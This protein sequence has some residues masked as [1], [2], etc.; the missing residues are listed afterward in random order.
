MLPQ[1]PSAG[2]PVTHPR[3]PSKAASAVPRRR[4]SPKNPALRMER[5][6]RA[7]VPATRSGR[8]AR[9]TR[10]GGKPVLTTAA[11]ASESVRKPLKSYELKELRWAGARGGPRRSSPTDCRG[12]TT[13]RGRP[14]PNPP[15]PGARLHPESR[16][17]PSSAAPAAAPSPGPPGIAT[18]V[19]PS[20]PGAGCP[21]RA[22]PAK[23]A[24]ARTLGPIASDVTK[25][26]AR[27]HQPEAAIASS[28]VSAG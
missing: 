22:K 3:A 17:R 26:V 15:G 10:S 9:A 2:D 18:T 19:E 14:A 13:R 4:V 23:P 5:T 7:R 28:G 27:L 12:P 21:P 16:R 8:P 24:T 1:I 20:N 25:V 11:D 6:I